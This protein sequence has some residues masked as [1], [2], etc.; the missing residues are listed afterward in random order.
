MYP[1][2][3]ASAAEIKYITIKAKVT[4]Y[5]TVRE[6]TD[7]TPCVGSLGTN[8][9]GR[10][11][12][13]ACPRILPL[14]TMIEIDGKQYICEDRLAIKFDDRF[15]I[16]CDKDMQCPYKISGQKQIKIYAQN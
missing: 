1:V 4:G 11:N 13:A 7:S 14:G 2:E 10:N 8:I 5:N 3:T 16:S 6:Q 12:V 9:C 15:D